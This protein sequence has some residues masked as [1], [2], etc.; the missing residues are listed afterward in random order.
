[1]IKQFLEGN[2]KSKTLTWSREWAGQ[3]RLQKEQASGN[4]ILGKWETR[5]GLEFIEAWVLVELCKQLVDKVLIGHAL[6]IL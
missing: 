3:G 6:A 2:E 4:K 5:Y 1:M